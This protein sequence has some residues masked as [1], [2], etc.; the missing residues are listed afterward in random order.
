MDKKPW[1]KSASG[2]AEGWCHAHVQAIIVAIDH[3][4]E[5]ALG[6]RELFSQQPYGVWG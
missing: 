4:A 6:T 3:M 2:D 5:A 1:R